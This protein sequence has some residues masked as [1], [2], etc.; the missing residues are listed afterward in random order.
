MLTRLLKPMIDYANFYHTQN[1]DYLK[2]NI[3]A[4]NKSSPHW[5]DITLVQWKRKCVRWNVV[6]MAGKIEK[7]TQEVLVDQLHIGL[8]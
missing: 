1:T 7:P 2:F 8:R 6:T 5:I 3:N 4:F